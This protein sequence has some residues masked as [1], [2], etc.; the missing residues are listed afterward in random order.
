MNPADRRPPPP[1]LPCTPMASPWRPQRIQVGEWRI[2]ALLDGTMRLDGG[3]MWGV[4][5]RAL[6][7]RMT[8]PHADH[9]ITLAIRPFLAERG[10]ARVVIEAGI[11]GHLDK[12][13]TKIYGVERTV[14]LES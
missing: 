3:S 11:G 7:E 12:K 8:P 13:W 6:W 9:T 1:R 14:T 4:V 10:D 5:P 2:T